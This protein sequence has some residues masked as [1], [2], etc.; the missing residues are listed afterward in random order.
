MEV[1]EECS[2]ECL[3]AREHYWML[4]Y[5]SIEDGMNMKLQ[6]PDGTTSLTDE[7]IEKI[8]AY[9][10]FRHM[11]DRGTGQL[12]KED[13]TGYIGYAKQMKER[14]GITDNVFHRSYSRYVPVK[15]GVGK[16]LIFRVVR[17]DEYFSLDF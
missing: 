8:R 16:G 2:I 1:L 15:K 7:S 13:T 3:S 10:L 9:Q 4:R 6:H 12:Y 5:N 11:G 17:D 14:F